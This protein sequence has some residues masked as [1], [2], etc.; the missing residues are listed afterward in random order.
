MKDFRRFGI[1]GL[2]A[3]LVC[4]GGG[5]AAQNQIPLAPTAGDP[6]VYS[7]GLTVNY[8]AG[9]ST[10]SA[11][12]DAS[13]YAYPAQSINDFLIVNST[14]PLNGFGAGAY[15]LTATVDNHG[16]L[17]GGT[18]NIYG[19][20]ID[21]DQ[22]PVRGNPNGDLLLSATL[23]PGRAGSSFG[24]GPGSLGNEDLFKLSF[25]VTGGAL[26]SDF[27]TLGNVGGIVLDANFSGSTDP[28]TGAWDTSF[29]NVNQ[30]GVADTFV[31]EPT[32]YATCAA[33]LALIS[34]LV[35]RIKPARKQSC[36]I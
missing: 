21:S 11:T 32:G 8:N 34:A 26:A 36:A 18:L 28:F 13:Q 24:W 33:G 31:P 5:A 27:L 30:N 22:N 2:C 19:V 15:S 23:R 1:I 6:D 4:F 20:V 12:G 17:L 10:F 16:N 3:E 29:G 9:N 14:D 25:T 7:S 35:S